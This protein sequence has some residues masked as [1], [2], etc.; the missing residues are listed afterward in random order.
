MEWQSDTKRSDGLYVCK[1]ADTHWA[2]RFKGQTITECP[3]CDKPLLTARAA[4]LV[5]DVV[6]KP[7]NGDGEP[8]AATA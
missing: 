3:C 1:L 6:F 2:I 8:P 4:R 5:A 7:A